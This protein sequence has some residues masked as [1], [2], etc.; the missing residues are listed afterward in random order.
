MIRVSWTGNGV[1]ERR[2]RIG[3]DRP[4]GIGHVVMSLGQGHDPDASLPDLQGGDLLEVSAELEVTTDLTPAEVAA[5]GGHG[6]AAKPYDYP[7]EVAASL[8]LGTDDRSTTPAGGTKE[9]ATKTASVTH[10]QH[11]QV[12]VFDRASITIPDGWNGRSA[13]NL[14]LG[15]SHAGAGAGQCLLIGQN[16]ADGSISTDMGGIS[17]CRI[18]GQIP[19]P[20]PMREIRLRVAGLKIHPGYNDPQVIYSMP[21]SG[22]RADQQMTIHAKIIASAAGLGTRARFSTRVF[23]ADSPNQL[24]PDDGYASKLAANKGRVAKRNGFNYVPG[25]P[26]VPTEKVGVLHVIENMPA[27]RTVYLNVVGDGG[28][29]SKKSQVG[30]QLKLQPGGFLEIRRYPAGSLG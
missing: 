14:V 28:D 4:P 7:P 15:A 6:C 19:Q 1:A 20:D 13:V 11:H 3:V 18:R 22:L 16:E 8:I 24:E 26:V 29:P 21:L 27:G 12:L 9:I 10:D 30:D 23:L 17:V 2:D 5:N 25:A